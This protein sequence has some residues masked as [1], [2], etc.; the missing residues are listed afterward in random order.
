MPRL[1]FLLFLADGPQP[2][3]EL[4]LDREIPPPVIELGGCAGHILREPRTYRFRLLRRRAA[5]EKIQAEYGEEL[6]PA[7]PPT[8]SWNKGGA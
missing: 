4:E 8:A 1:C 2:I 6:S 5:G 3:L 7:R